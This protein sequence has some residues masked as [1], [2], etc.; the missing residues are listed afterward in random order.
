MEEACFSL[1]HLTSSDRP[2]SDAPPQIFPSHPSSY[3]CGHSYHCCIVLSHALRPHSVSCGACCNHK[4]RGRSDHRQ[5]WRKV[6]SAKRLSLPDVGSSSQSLSEASLTAS[7]HCA[8]EKRAGKDLHRRVK[9]LEATTVRD[10]RQCRATGTA[11]W[12]L[13][14]AARSAWSVTVSASRSSDC[15]QALLFAFCSC[16]SQK[17]KAKT[18]W[19]NGRALDTGHLHGV[20]R[21]WPRAPVTS[22]VRTC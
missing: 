19:P 18:R 10:R 12:I 5:S 7:W 13:A 14:A 4:R 3:S 16:W 1:K 8:K 6:H 9:E 2:T 20:M 22:Q 21:P 17:G 15:C 11:L